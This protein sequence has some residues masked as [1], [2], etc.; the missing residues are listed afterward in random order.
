MSV[1]DKE[2]LEPTGITREELKALVDEYVANGGKITECKPGTALNYR[3]GIFESD[4]VSK[5]ARKA[6]NS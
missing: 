2:F 4:A 1:I 5:P 6:K 3:G